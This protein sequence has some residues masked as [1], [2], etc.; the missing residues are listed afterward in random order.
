[1]GDFKR[2]V[3]WQEGHAFALA[4]HRAFAG[5]RANALTGGRAQIIRAV[6]SIPDNLAEGFAKR[7]RREL[8]RYAEMAYASA[9]EDENQL[10]KARDLEILTPAV[11]AELLRKGGR[12]TALCFAL[13][14]LP[15]G[16]T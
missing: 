2:L 12:V 13:S 1:M 8:A 5:R 10:I 3:A 11:A 15:P 4:I 14:R 7:S 9:K 6:N 16:A